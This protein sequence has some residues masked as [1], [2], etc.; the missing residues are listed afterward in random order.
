MSESDGAVITGRKRSG[1]RFSAA[2]PI[3]KCLHSHLDPPKL[4]RKVSGTPKCIAVASSQ[5]LA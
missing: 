3:S 5:A 1:G 2:A 4:A